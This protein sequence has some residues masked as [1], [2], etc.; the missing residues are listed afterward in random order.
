[1]NYVSYANTSFVYSLLSSYLSDQ[2][3][4]EFINDICN[5]VI[6]NLSLPSI[7]TLTGKWTSSD[8]CT[9][10]SSQDGNFWKICMDTGAV[11]LNNIPV[12]NF[13][14]SKFEE[15]QL[16]NHLFGNKKFRYTQEG[17]WITFRDHN[18]NC[19]RFKKPCGSNDYWFYSP[20][21]SKSEFDVLERQF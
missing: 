8:I 21:E 3:D 2:S 14:P 7:K 11:Y 10:T 15:T 5:T 9:F 12:T 17:D 6:N 13:D 18:M 20:F 19:M 1:M 16:Y 4:R